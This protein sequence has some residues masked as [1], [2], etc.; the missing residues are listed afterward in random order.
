MKSQKFVAVISSYRLL[1]HGCNTASDAIDAPDCFQTD[2][3]H[4]TN[5]HGFP[6]II[7]GIDC[8]QPVQEKGQGRKRDSRTD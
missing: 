1:L 6:I 5:F 8:G 4:K 2:A 7:T 3:T